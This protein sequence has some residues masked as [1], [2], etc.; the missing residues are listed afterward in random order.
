MNLLNLWSL[1][2]ESHGTL[3]LDNQ[4]KFKVALITLLSKL[5]LRACSVSPPRVAWCD[6]SCILYRCLTQYKACTLYV[7]W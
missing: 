3:E 4:G 1:L 6:E 5:L 2:S 7:H